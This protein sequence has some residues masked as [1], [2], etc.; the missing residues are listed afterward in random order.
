MFFFSFPLFPFSPITFHLL[1]YYLSPRFSHT[2]NLSLPQGSV[3]MIVTMALVSI[4]AILALLQSVDRLVA[5]N[6]LRTDSSD[7]APV[8]NSI[9]FHSQS[10]YQQIEDDDSSELRR[11]D[12]Y[13]GAPLVG[14]VQTEETQAMMERA[15]KIV[16]FFLCHSPSLSP[17]LSLSLSLCLPLLNIYICIIHLTSLSSFLSLSLSCLLSLSTPLGSQHLRWPRLCRLW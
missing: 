6:E 13:V 2:P 15:R 14:E 3:A 4:Y 8:E 10:S 5:L 7:S 16:R 12:G 9:Q 1:F 17:S 11:V